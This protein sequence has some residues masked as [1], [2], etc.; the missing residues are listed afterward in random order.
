MSKNKRIE[1][2]KA[3]IEKVMIVCQVYKTTRDGSYG[4]CL[5]HNGYGKLS[6]ELKQ[7]ELEELPSEED[8]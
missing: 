2:V 8:E 7:L 4:A 5:A 6:D 3:E 1:E